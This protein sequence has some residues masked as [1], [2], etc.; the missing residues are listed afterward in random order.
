MDGWWDYRRVPGRYTAVVS[1]GMFGHVGPK[2]HSAYMAAVDRCLG[3]GG[4]SLLHTITS[5]TRVR[6]GEPWLHRYIFPG[7]VLP[8]LA[9]ITEAARERLVVED[10]QNLGPDYDWTLMAWCRRFEAAWPDLGE[11]YDERFRRPWRYYLL[12]CAG[13][14][15]ARHLQGHQLVHTRRGTPPSGMRPCHLIR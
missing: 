6:H 12:S 10:F 5:G 8:T 4:V 3:D 14:F 13:L 2:S 9:G 15:R 7:A 1:M 11:R